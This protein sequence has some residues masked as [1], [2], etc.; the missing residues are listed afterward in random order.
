M[1]LKQ[2]SWIDEIHNNLLH[3][4]VHMYDVYTVKAVV[5]L[6]GSL[7][8]HIQSNRDNAKPID[9]VDRSSERG[10]SIWQILQALDDP[11]SHKCLFNDRFYHLKQ[12][13]AFGPLYE[14]NVQNMKRSNATK[15]T[16]PVLLALDGGG[17]RGITE[18][19]FTKNLTG[20]DE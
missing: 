1:E 17:I 18:I 19:R 4:A 12:K 14:I 7:N 15:E 2:I 5:V 3:R 20:E 16:R 11:K 10:N 13:Y 6:Y 9:V 8:L